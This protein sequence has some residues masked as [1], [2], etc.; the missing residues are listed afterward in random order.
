MKERVYSKSTPKLD[1][2][3]EGDI[4]MLSIRK[5]GNKLVMEK[6]STM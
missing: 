3:G 1:T 5:G 2:V 6:D 4:T